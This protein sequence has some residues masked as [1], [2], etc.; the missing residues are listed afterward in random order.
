MAVAKLFAFN[1]N[2]ITDSGSLTNGNPTSIYQG[3]LGR[4]IIKNK[5]V[6]TKKLYSTCFLQLLLTDI[7]TY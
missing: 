2:A 4:G 1:A 7:L 6:N 3:V 5:V